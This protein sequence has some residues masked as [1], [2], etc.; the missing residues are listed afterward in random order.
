MKVCTN[1]PSSVSGNIYETIQLSG[2]AA[3][4]EISN[5]YATIIVAAFLIID[6]V[7]FCAYPKKNDSKIWRR[8]WG[9]FG[10]LWF[11]AAIVLSSMIIDRVNNGS[12]MVMNNK[13][14]TEIRMNGEVFTSDLSFDGTSCFDVVLDNT[15]YEDFVDNCT[16][17]DN[18]C[19]SI[20]LTDNNERKIEIGGTVFGFSILLLVVSI[21]AFIMH[22][23]LIF[24][25]ALEDVKNKIKSLCPTPKISTENRTS[26]QKYITTGYRRTERY[27][28]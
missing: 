8:S 4:G 17:Y 20:V 9:I 6:L 18:T 25:I 19:D 27:L 14:M 26:P 13:K 11:G 24:D 10:V 3:N 1:N 12:Y 16:P 5:F 7:L 2:V 21:F 28:F 15:T 22:I 23:F